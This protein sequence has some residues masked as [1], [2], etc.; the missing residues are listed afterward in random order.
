MWSALVLSL[1]GCGKMAVDG[2]VVDVTGEPIAGATVTLVGS[3]C[4]V[5]TDETGRFALPC[6]PGT[7]DLHIGA[8]G[9]IEDKTK[10]FEAT[11][12]KR[13]DVGSK[14][15][16][17]MPTEKGLML[18]DGN[19]YKPM[20]RGLLER[21]KGGT[22]Q[23]DMYKYWCLPE[24]KPEATILPE[25]RHNFFDNESVGW[26]PFRL[27]EEGCAYRMSP[28]SETAWGVDYAEKAEF[29]TH[30]VEPGKEVV[31]MELPAGEYFIADWDQGFFTKGQVD[32]K[33]G[34]VGH[35]LVVQ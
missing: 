10:D 18:L 11:E 4:Q 32:G 29:I 35:Y 13:Y 8:D 28:H 26:R 15:L 6:L 30:Q 17:T 31:L 21:E 9:Y 7:Y 24:E 16:I 34:S 23:E 27:D 1:V 2:E 33:K 19:G 22:T 5:V 14:M 20:P 25:G 12:R 3:H